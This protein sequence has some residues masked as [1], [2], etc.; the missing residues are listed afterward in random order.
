[1]INKLNGE[2]DSNNEFSKLVDL[3]NISI[4]NKSSDILILE[5][6]LIILM[7]TKLEV[8]LEN[9]TSK[10]FESIKNDPNNTAFNLSDEIKR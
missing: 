8:F 1:M 6:M 3:V 5:K 2:L 7:V 9:N 4:K 10:W